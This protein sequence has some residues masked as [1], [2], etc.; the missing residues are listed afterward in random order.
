MKIPFYL[1]LHLESKNA[2]ETGVQQYKL[3]HQCLLLYGYVDLHPILSAKTHCF[4]FKFRCK[5]TTQGPYFV[6]VDQ[7]VAANAD[8]DE[9]WQVFVLAG[10]LGLELRQVLMNDVIEQGGLGL[11]AYLSCLT[12]DRNHWRMKSA[13]HF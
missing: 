2:Q 4:W 12:G 10:Q 1:P 3:E 13:K 9:S 7:L 11:V 5:C 8:S 6:T